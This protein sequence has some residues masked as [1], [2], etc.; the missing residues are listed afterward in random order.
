MAATLRA[1]GFGGRELARD[2]ESVKA[3]LSR[4]LTAM[5]REAAE[6]VATGARGNMR[7]GPGPRLAAKNPNDDRLP[8]IRDTI[9]GQAR[10]VVS[11]HPAAKVWEFGGTIAPSG[12]PIQIPR[13]EM[14]QRAGRDRQD[15][16]ERLMADRVEDLLDR[17]V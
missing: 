4:E 17:N 16:I 8:H 12:A 11:S 6:L 7:Y 9:S 10:G 14:A 1:K 3:G 13:L 2:L 5:K 15:D